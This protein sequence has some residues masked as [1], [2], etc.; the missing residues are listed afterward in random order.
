MYLLIFRMTSDVIPINSLALMIEL[1]IIIYAIQN[2][3]QL[4]SVL[5]SGPQPC[6]WPSQTPLKYQ[7]PAFSEISCAF[8]STLLIQLKIEILVENTIH[9]AKR[10]PRCSWKSDTSPNILCSV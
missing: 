8:S 5:Y 2:N 10:Y 4:L 6:I 7:A 3:H 1:L 9:D